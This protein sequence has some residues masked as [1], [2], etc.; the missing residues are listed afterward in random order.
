MATCSACGGRYWPKDKESHLAYDCFP[1]P[2]SVKAK[3]A[4]APASGS[5]GEKWRLMKN[6]TIT[7]LER[8]A[9]DLRPRRSRKSR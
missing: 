8:K 6:S 1:S 5:P 2:Y 4:A 7:P 3:P 9:L